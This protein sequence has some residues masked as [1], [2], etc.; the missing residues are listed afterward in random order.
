MDHLTVRLRIASR[1]RQEILTHPHLRLPDRVLA[2]AL[3]EALRMVVSEPLEL[4]ALVT[5]LCDALGTN[6][7]MWA[8]FAPITQSIKAL[9]GYLE[10]DP[11]A[12]ESKV[13]R[14]LG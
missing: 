10:S 13:L 11:A 2:S 4:K 6:H 8:D 7:A 5:T 3:D 9:W 1:L 14:S 12:T